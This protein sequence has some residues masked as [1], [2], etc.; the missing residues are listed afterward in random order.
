MACRRKKDKKNRVPWKQ[1][2]SMLFRG[3]GGGY[4]FL[5][6]AG[7]NG[8]LTWNRSTDSSS[9]EAFTTLNHSFGPV[10]MT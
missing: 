5:T 9:P 8:E 3:E 10:N 1:E 4:G 2:T 6:P 7:S